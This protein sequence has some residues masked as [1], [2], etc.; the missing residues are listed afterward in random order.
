MSLSK[1]TLSLESIIDAVCKEFDLKKEDIMSEN[2][3][4]K[5]SYGRAMIS[6]IA[7]NEGKVPVIEIATRLNRSPNAISMLL[8]RFYEREHS[9]E[10]FEKEIKKMKAKVL[11]DAN[12]EIVT[13][14]P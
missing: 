5:C 7:V 14:D 6:A 2:R 3:S 8:S 12:R 1:Q 13:S 11:K 9:S 10:T 4:H